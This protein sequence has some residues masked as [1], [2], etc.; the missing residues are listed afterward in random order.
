MPFIVRARLIRALLPRTPTRQ[1]RAL[2]LTVQCLVAKFIRT[3]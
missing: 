3:R 1:A 2:S